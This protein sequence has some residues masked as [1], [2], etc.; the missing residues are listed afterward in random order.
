MDFDY[1][2]VGAGF[3]GSVCAR[4]LADEGKKILIIDKREH[5]GGN[6]YEKFD[7]ESG[8]LIHH[9]DLHILHKKVKK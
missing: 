4:C 3:A 2:I 6:A 8:L 5:L 7:Y 9:H 1:L